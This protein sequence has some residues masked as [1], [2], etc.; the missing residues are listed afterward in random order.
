MTTFVKEIQLL[1]RAFLTSLTFCMVSE[2]IIFEFLLMEDNT[3]LSRISSNH[4]DTCVVTGILAPTIPP[5]FDVVL[6]KIFF[7]D[8]YTFY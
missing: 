3:P 1:F 7:G 6:P 4:S 8:V 5:G 2:L